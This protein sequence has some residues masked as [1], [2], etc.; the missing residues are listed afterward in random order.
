MSAQHVHISD[1]SLVSAGEATGTSDLQTLAPAVHAWEAAEFGPAIA[2]EISALFMRYWQDGIAHADINPARP[3]DVIDLAPGNGY[4]GHQLIRFLQSGCRQVNG[5]QFRYLPV[6]PDD[7]WL[8]RA[9][10]ASEMAQHYRQ[11]LLLPLTGDPHAPGCLMANGILYEAH[12]PVLILV[13]DAWARL[14]QRLLAVHYGKL[15]EA[16]LELIRSGQVAGSDRQEWRIA[17]PDL[18]GGEHGPLFA[19]YLEEFNSSPICFPDGAIGAWQRWRRLARHGYLMLAYGKGVASEL[20]MRLHTFP[21]LVSAYREEARMPVHFGLFAHSAHLRGAATIE[22]DLPDGKGM[23]IMLEA[24]ESS[25]QRLVSVAADFDSGIFQ[26]RALVSE[27]M[28]SLGGSHKLDFLRLLLELSGHDPVLFAE[29]ARDLSAV[30]SK[31]AEF[32]RASWRNTLDEVWANFLPELAGIRLHE[33]LSNA[34]MHCGH[35]RLARQALERGMHFHGE[36]AADLANLAWCEMR[37][38]QMSVGMELVRQALDMDA[39]NA[40]ALQVNA[41]MHERLAQRDDAWRVELRNPASLLT[42]EP[43]DLSH[44]EA[45]F[46]QYRDPQISI[47]TGLPP[48]KSVEETRQW[49]SAGPDE[50]GRVSFAVLHRDH[51]FVAYVNLAV[52]EHAAFFCFWTGVDFQGQGYATAAARLVFSHAA[53]MGVHLML[54]SAYKDNRR[55]IRALERLGFVRIPSQA[56]PPDHERVFFVRAGAASGDLDAHKEL[57]D[58]YR[59]E[60][61]PLRFAG[62]TEISSTDSADH[63][64]D[65]AGSSGK[66]P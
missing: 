50:R 34:A 52:S 63:H 27:A 21:D 5:A 20:R 46:L 43:L 51:G 53:A 39:G 14:P 48:L 31:T 16:D 66:L 36:H 45:Y 17:G 28:R 57:V 37:T 61:L 58:Y 3:I 55:S 40:V 24:M 12:N 13:H 15:M 7:A 8:H 19:R 29:I 18:L 42:L 47:M 33:K 54:T 62:E 49:I 25:E 11:G 64:T 2:K 6:V 23:Q 22:R 56:L 65:A 1:Q 35:W 44:A 10:A 59:R 41:R 30:F 32:D 60:N 26:R 4:N 38:G 9:S